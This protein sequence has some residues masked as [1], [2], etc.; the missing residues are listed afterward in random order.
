MI[1]F[2]NTKTIYDL[3][4]RVGMEFENNVFIRYEKDDIIYEKGYGTFPLDTMAMAAYT[5]R[6]NQKFTHPVHIALL[7]KCG[8]EYIT[9][10]LGAPCAGGVSYPVDIQSSN[11]VLVE[12]L[13][14]ADIDIV[15]Y[16]RDFT[17]QV[18]YLKENCS[19]IKKYICLQSVKN[20][21][22]VPQIQ[23]EYR[24]KTVQNLPKPKDCA[25]LIF[26]SGTTGHGKG[27]MLSHANI[28]DNMFCTDGF[29]DVCLNVLPINHI[30]CI[31][32]DIMLVLRY[33]STL[34]LCDDLKKM[35]YYIKL[36]QPTAMRVVPMMA[37]MFVN[38]V[39]I[40]QEKNPK[41]SLMDVK[42]QV[43]G[44]RMKRL[45][46]GGGYLSPDLA[47]SLMAL[48]ITAAQGYGMSECSPKISVPD[49]ERTDKLDSVGHLVTGCEVR[50]VDQEIQVKS[51]SV[52]MGYYNDPELTAEAITEDGWLKTGDLGYV[53]E[54]GFLYLNGRKKNLIILSNGENVS[55]EMIENRFDKDVLIAD[56]VAYG[57]NDRIVAEVY[58][59]Y[60]Y[61][62]I[63]GCT[64]IPS[65]VKEVVALRNQELPTYA[66]IADVTV[67]EHPFPK[68]ASKKI[69]RSKFFEEKKK[70]EQTE[71]VRRLPETP[72]QRQLFEIV[73]GVLGH[74]NFGIDDDFGKTGLDSLGSTLL[75]ADLSDALGLNINF[76]TL[77]EH[78]TIL[79]LEQLLK[80]QTGGTKL[81]LS[82]RKVYPL[83]GLQK[84]FAYVIPEN[85]TG[86]LPFAFRLDK[87]IDLSRLKA[88]CYQV[89]DAHPG[90]KGII[91][92]DEQGYYALYRDDTR[93]IDIPVKQVPDDEVAELMQ[94]LIV[95]FTYRET[96]DLVHIYL[97]EG[98]EYHYIF[99]DAAHIMGDGVTM[100]ILMEDL[101]RAY[102]G[103]ALEVE[104]Y[105]A[106]E[107][108]LEEHERAAM[109]ITERDIRYVAGLMNGM[110]MNRSLLNKTKKEDM[111]MPRNG[112]LRKTFERLPRKE[113]LY[114]GKKHG[115]SENAVFISAFNYCISL[116][117][118]EKDVFC[119]SIHSGR[120]DG[121]WNRL[122][123]C[124]FET[125]YCRYT[126]VPHEKT[127][128]LITK[129]GQQIMKTMECVT[130]CNRE[131]EMFIQFQGDILETPQIG[132]LPTER[133]RVQLDSL[134]FH[135]QIMY[136]ERGYYYEL[137]YWENRFDRDVLEVFLTC[138]ESVLL[139]MLEETSV[140]KLKRHMPEE[141]YPSRYTIEAGKLNQAAGYTLVPD[142]D[143]D[144]LLRVYV[145]DDDLNKKPYGAWG[146]FYIMNFQPERYTDVGP[147]PFGP[148]VVYQTGVTARI[149]PDGSLDFL[150]KAG[151]TVVT[152][153]G[154]GR[155]FFDLALAEEHLLARP[156]I[157]KAYCYMLYDPTVHDMVL[158][159]EIETAPG[160]NPADVDIEGLRQELI[161]EYG[162]MLCPKYVELV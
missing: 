25:M 126:Q 158:K 34:C 135:L 134:P 76:A 67:R 11:E 65:K 39:T 93:V 74:K 16:D 8:Y 112:V 32:S 87:K 128:D 153:G 86:N 147:Y 55:P 70:Q 38:R 148:G 75:I 58:P 15:F 72:V 19:F 64:D 33:G 113:L 139:A 151:R 54:E 142:V 118:D 79:G 145:L 60:E 42:A 122:A 130:S 136:N 20:V 96:D 7:G 14:K 109:G 102:A 161:Q 23:K 18:S 28:I 91:R 13:T 120:T 105:T 12:N 52:M 47:R 97:F 95:P 24:G 80:E 17:S 110:K 111:R 63:N 21:R 68:T 50:I 73:S 124:L 156:E 92:P 138:Y 160:V 66:Q 4:K 46:S 132:G 37:K 121:R 83:T 29:Q 108:A 26:T 51:P 59:N 125:Y 131:G 159:A 129:T 107:Y 10:L 114:Y 157:A 81:D 89:L 44:P 69:I 31:S 106:Y 101:N 53:D 6:Q 115:V 82:V 22:T 1:T 141:V 56:I 152:D 43:L 133:I 78:K 61:A 40:M 88:A 2:N 123:G 143:E 45:I 27:V 62:Q 77:M 154:S 41:L 150:E 146:Q 137:R 85:T 155:R 149:L 140:R 3:V 57:Q 162:E 144:Q 35:F 71:F 36:F 9:V 127:Y 117:S 98:Q 30:F 94:K 48:G 5:E 84:Y 49:Y 116:F 90:L 100:N 104:K 99:F 119:T 103:E